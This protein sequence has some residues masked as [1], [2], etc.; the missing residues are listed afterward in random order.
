MGIYKNGPNAAARTRMAWRG[1]GT[2]IEKHENRFADSESCRGAGGR[3]RRCREREKQASRRLAAGGGLPRGAHREV[4]FGGRTRHGRARSRRTI[5][6]PSKRSIFAPSPV[7][8]CTPAHRRPV[9]GTASSPS[10]WHPFST[11]EE[12]QVGGAP[13]GRTNGGRDSGGMWGKE[14][15]RMARM[16]RRGLEGLGGG[17]EST[18]K[19]GETASRT[20]NG[21]GGQARAPLG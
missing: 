12:R 19:S 17:K 6:E 13:C 11:R 4:F 9:S 1:E 16:P 3:P 20:W 18:L 10:R 5:S 8:S 7:S 2:N 15:T 21:T 14:S